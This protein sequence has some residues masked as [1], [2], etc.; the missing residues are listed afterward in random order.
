MSPSRRGTGPRGLS[1]EAIHDA[2]IAVMEETGE[3]GFTVRKVAARAGCD[4]MTVLYHAGSKER[5]Q[6]AMIDRITGQLPQLPPDAPWQSRLRTL[7]RG[8]RALAL[9]YPRTFKLMPRVMNSGPAD[10]AMTE[11]TFQA[12]VDAGVPDRQVPALCWGLHASIIGL[13]LGEVGGMSTPASTGELAEL[14]ALPADRFPHTR[15]FADFYARL[16]PADVFEHTLDALLAGVAQIA[17][18]AR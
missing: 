18:R 9:R 4:P 11:M 2:G 14:A 8:Y 10:A 6:R 1:T 3:A 7:A 13:C 16:E 12:L 15:R 17:E 5:L